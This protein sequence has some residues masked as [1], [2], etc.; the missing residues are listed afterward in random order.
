MTS[1]LSPFRRFDTIPACNGRTNLVHTHT[2]PIISVRSL[3]PVDNLSKTPEANS[4][5]N[6]SSSSRVFG[7]RLLEIHAQSSTSGRCRRK[8]GLRRL[9]Y[10]TVAQS[11]PAVGRGFLFGP[12]EPP[13]REARFQQMSD[14]YIPRYRHITA[15]IFMTL[16]IRCN[17]SANANIA[18][19]IRFTQLPLPTRNVL[20]GPYFTFWPTVV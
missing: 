10:A 12:S 18:Y 20:G 5:G 15:L 4:F 1:L 11:P 17:N 8:V 16:P 9:R 13:Y 19:R 14:D 3:C 2:D 6:R 7:V